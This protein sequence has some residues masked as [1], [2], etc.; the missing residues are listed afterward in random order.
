MQI[1]I[2]EEADFNGVIDL[3]EQEAIFWEDELGTEPVRRE[4]PAELQDQAAFDRSNM[5]EKIAEI[6]D[7]L[8]EKY[9]EDPR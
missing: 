5:I 1:P 3:V 2:G 7:E 8:L 4:I 6:D 9:L